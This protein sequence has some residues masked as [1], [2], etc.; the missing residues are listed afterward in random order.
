LGTYLS[1]A[2]VALGARV[3]EKHLTLDTKAYGPDHRASLDVKAFSELIDEVRSVE[4]ALGTGVK[5]PTAQELET[6]KLA[7]RGLYAARDLNPGDLVTASDIAILRPENGT[8]PKEYWSI[9]GSR[10]RK[11][12]ACGDDFHL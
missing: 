8:S 10:V 11:P 5:T 6:A 7:R 4:R 3:I 2:A 12:L 9:I 1:V